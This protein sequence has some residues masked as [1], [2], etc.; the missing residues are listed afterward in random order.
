[1]R[2]SQDQISVLQNIKADKLF[3][4]LLTQDE[5]K[6]IKAKRKKPVAE[7]TKKVK[8]EDTK[9]ADVPH[10]GEIMELGVDFDLKSLV[11]SCIDPKTGKMRELVDTRSLPEAKNFY[12]FCY[13]ILGSDIHPPWAVQMWLASM[14]LG[15]VCPRCTK[16]KYMDVFQIDKKMSSKDLN[17][18]NRMTFLEHGVCPRCGAT[19]KEIL[20]NKELPNYDQA[21]FILGQ[22]SGKS[23]T[24]AIMAAYVLHRYLMY[25]VL[26]SMTDSM[27]ASTELVFIF[28]SLTYQK[29]YDVLWTPFKNI[30]TNAQWFK[31]YYQLLDQYKEQY[32]KDLY[33]KG[34]SVLA[35]ANKN[36]KCY[37][38]GPTAS[39]LR[40][41]TAIMTLLDELGLFPLPKPDEV[42]DEND[43]NRRASADE[44]Y[45]SLTNSLTTVEAARNEL[46]QRGFNDAPPCL[47]LSVS[48]P[49]SKR[50]KVMRLFADS[51]TNPFIFA[52]RMATW[53]VNPHLE[54][55]S[56]PIASAFATSERKALRDFGAQ[57]AEGAAPYFPEES[58]IACFC[59]RPNSHTLQY[60]YDD[61]N[62]FVWGTVRK[63]NQCNEPTVMALDAGLVNNSFAIA[64]V[65]YN[66][67]THKTETVCVLE[68][69]AKDNNV[70][71]FENLYRAV[72]LPLC[73]QLNVCLVIADRWNSVDHLHRIRN[74]R[75]MRQGKPITHVK[76][77]SLKVK[78][79]EAVR[80][81]MAN[82]TVT[83]PAISK[84]WRQKILDGQIGDYK[85]D[86]F[87]RPVEHFFLQLLTVNDL[88]PGL[89]PSKAEGL[90]DDIARAWI[91][92]V[93]TINREKV[94]E[95]VDNNRRFVKSTSAT[96]GKGIFVLGRSF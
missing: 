77:Y 66:Q 35:F 41:N 25:P 92:A 74:D 7:K 43:T 89:C 81:M 72:I 93:A 26:S 16:P 57:P 90:T 58:V 40:G 47:M 78:D 29:A 20:N 56:G 10:T 94:M 61:K 8:V 39:R 15:E 44:A 95:L 12:D 82:H 42:V 79:F 67:Q 14:A 23:T 62:H 32:G 84:E 27:Q 4:A 52:A 60:Q 87:G 51:K 76:Q 71:N 38:V 70:V 13:R 50:D 18:K 91:L 24:A 49:V 48:S 19:R 9:S 3:P 28:C 22:R 36:I 2:L 21:V 85:T 96:Y 83:S 53:Q 5:K 55:T 46:I 68:V 1:M 54:I 86:L 31:A 75:G 45:T 63:V 17:S 59:G 69:I 6:K 37:P 88:G 65:S 64:V 34:E 30:V 11:N 73:E 33:V 80:A